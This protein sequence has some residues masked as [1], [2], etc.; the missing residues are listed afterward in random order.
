MQCVIEKEI[1]FHNAFVKCENDV[2]L[3]DFGKME[4]QPVQ[5]SL[6]LAVCGCGTNPDFMP[7]IH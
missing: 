4:L 3:P 2:F 1:S 6:N 5:F 7:L